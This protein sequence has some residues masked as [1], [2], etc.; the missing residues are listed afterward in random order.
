MAQDFLNLKFGVGT[1]NFPN[2]GCSE[3][4]SHVGFPH[5]PWPVAA[6]FLNFIFSFFCPG[7]GFHKPNM[8]TQ[9]TFLLFCVFCGM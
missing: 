1:S 2:V 6:F 7:Y 4:M 5:K 3:V 9:H 8:K